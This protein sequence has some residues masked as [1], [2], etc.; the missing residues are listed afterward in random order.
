MQP[1]S[2]SFS[3]SLFRGQ[4]YCSLAMV[5][6]GSTVAVSKI[7]GQEMEPFLATAWRHALALPVFLLLMRL[8][9]L[10][11]PRRMCWQD[12]LLL[13]VQSAAGSVGYTVLL[14]KGVTHSGAG[15]ASVMAGTLPAVSALVAWL[16]VGEKPTLRMV[17]SIA[18][19]TLGV[20]AVVAGNG[21]L[22]YD[23]QHLLGHTLILCAILCET[24]F[25]LLNKRLRAPLPALVQSALMSAGGLLL[26]GMVAV[27]L[28]GT[29]VGTAPSAAAWWGVLYYA[30]V[31]TVAGF[32]LWYQGSARIPAA[33]A[34]LTTVL[35]PV[36]AMLFSVLVTGEQVGPWQWAGLGC[37]TFSVLLGA[38]GR[39]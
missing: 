18:L 25:I 8:A 10:R 34:A 38:G 35:L 6:V 11:W 28:H 39:G 30:L 3:S 16:V 23:P 32:L 33:R 20:L 1:A 21:A 29:A 17:A 27:G 31:P 5:T 7:I 9:G 12:A 22:H 19:A 37:V 13:L 14:I 24:F 2:S 26:S 4:V 15:D 36:S